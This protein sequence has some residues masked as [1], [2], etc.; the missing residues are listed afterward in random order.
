MKYMVIA[1]PSAWELW[2]IQYRAHPWQ[3]LCIE[4]TTGLEGLGVITSEIL[5]VLKYPEIYSL[6]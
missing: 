3:G 1:M 2:S 5:K 4:A 6:S